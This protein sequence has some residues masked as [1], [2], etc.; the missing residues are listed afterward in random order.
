VAASKKRGRKR[1][2]A[3][4][5]SKAKRARKSEVEIA[6]D[7]IAAEGMGNYYTVFQLEGGLL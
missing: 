5:G 1:K 2:N 4:A 3:P 7:E 6:E